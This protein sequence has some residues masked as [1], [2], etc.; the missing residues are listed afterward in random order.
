MYQIVE[1]NQ[2]E[3]LN[4]IIGADCSGQQVVVGKVYPSPKALT[5]DTELESCTQ[6]SSK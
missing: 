3:S 2:V 5:T 6:E 4:D 1:I